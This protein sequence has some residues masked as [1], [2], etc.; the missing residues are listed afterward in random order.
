MDRLVRQ[1]DRQVDINS[2]RKIDRQKQREREREID[3]NRERERLLA[4]TGR[5]Q[6]IR[7]IIF[8]Q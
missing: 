8:L 2:Y 5:V 1:V 7:T 4:Y 6:N 3:K